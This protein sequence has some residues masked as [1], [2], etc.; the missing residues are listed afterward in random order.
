[1]RLGFGIMT[2]TCIILSALLARFISEYYV[3][4]RFQ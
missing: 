4:A 3:S 2:T 1:M